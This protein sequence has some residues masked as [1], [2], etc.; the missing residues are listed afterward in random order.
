MA[1]L[2]I[3]FH[4]PHPSLEQA[5]DKDRG[6]DL[7]KCQPVYSQAWAAGIEEGRGPQPGGPAP[8][9]LSGIP[10]FAG[11]AGDPSRAL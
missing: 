9:V 10:A 11:C 8:M 3:P 2:I 5:G 4:T 6:Q 7:Q 1:G